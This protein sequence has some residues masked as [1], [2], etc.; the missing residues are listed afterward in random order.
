VIPAA[1]HAAHGA[2]EPVRWSTSGRGAARPMA[3][4]APSLTTR[5]EAVEEASQ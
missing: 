4:P 2:A 5:S 3:H 1:W